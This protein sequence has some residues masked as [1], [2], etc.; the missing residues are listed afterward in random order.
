MPNKDPIVIKRPTGD[1]EHIVY[2]VSEASERRLHVHIARIGRDVEKERLRT[3]KP[4]LTDEEY[5]QHKADNE[6]NLIEGDRK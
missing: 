5:E 3:L 6:N 1:G 2:T 4:L